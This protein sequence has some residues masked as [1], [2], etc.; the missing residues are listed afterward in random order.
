MHYDAL[1]YYVNTKLCVFNTFYHQTL[2][3]V[4]SIHR[5]QA[6]SCSRNHIQNIFTLNAFL[7]PLQKYINEMAAT[8]SLNW[9]PLD[10]NVD[11]V[12]LRNITFPYKLLFYPFSEFMDNNED[13]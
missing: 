4:I 5:A 3:A 6:T 12:S 7:L 11:I 9:H 10:M 1:S 8:S 13:N 2:V